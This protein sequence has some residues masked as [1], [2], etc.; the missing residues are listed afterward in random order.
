VDF[1]EKIPGLTERERKLILGEN[2]QR[3]LRL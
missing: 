2:A 3:F 1:V